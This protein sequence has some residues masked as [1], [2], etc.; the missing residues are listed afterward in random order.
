[1]TG[2]DE[3]LLLAAKEARARADRM[4]ALANERERDGNH[5]T[6]RKLREQAAIL[7]DFAIWCESTAGQ[8][9]GASRVLTI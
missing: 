1:M 3:G 8:Y 6:E 4:T 9:I 5:V 7:T 2:R